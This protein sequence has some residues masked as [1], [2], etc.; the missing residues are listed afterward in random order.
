MLGHV[1]WASWFW[2]GGTPCFEAAWERRER[3]HFEEHA[4]RTD[5]KLLLVQPELQ[6]G[7]AA[8]GDTAEGIG[9]PGQPKEGTMGMRARAQ[10]RERKTRE[11]LLASQELAIIQAPWS[12]VG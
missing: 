2:A 11:I 10:E 8:V 5:R 6:L 12:A 7:L 3:C 1:A 4:H 9:E